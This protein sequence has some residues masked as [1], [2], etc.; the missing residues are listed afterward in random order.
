MTLTDDGDDM[1]M[2]AQYGQMDRKDKD[3]RLNIDGMADRFAD[4][5]TY[6]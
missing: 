6:T 2:I 5:V 4:F 3:L 1:T